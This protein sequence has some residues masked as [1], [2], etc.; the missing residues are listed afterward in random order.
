M[1]GSMETILQRT[2]PLM[3]LMKKCN[4]FVL[5]AAMATRL[6]YY[7]TSHRADWTAVSS[8]LLDFSNEMVTLA[9]MLFLAERWLYPSKQEMA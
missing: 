3:G 5:G 9:L 4:K 2:E 8:S 6:L 7:P 1:E